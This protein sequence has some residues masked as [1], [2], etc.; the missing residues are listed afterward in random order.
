MRIEDKASRASF[1]IRAHWWFALVLL[2]ATDLTR[3]ATKGMSLKDCDFFFA[4]II[5]ER[6]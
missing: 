6:M 2:A 4:I 5:L 3:E 1:E